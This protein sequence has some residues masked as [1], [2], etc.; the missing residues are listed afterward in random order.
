M[1]ITGHVPECVGMGIV[2]F[3]LLIAL[4]N[5]GRGLFKGWFEGYDFLPRE[6]EEGHIPPEKS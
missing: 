6:E 2:F 1:H 3:L 5:L 4:W